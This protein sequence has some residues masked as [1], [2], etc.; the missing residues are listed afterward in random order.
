MSQN[1]EEDTACEF[2]IIFSGI[3]YSRI[4]YLFS[5]QY[6]LVR[7]T[8]A[9]F[10]TLIRPVFSGTRYWCICNH[11]FCPTFSRYKIL[12]HFFPLFCTIFSGTKYSHIFQQFFHTIFSAT[13]YFRIFSDFLVILYVVQNTHAFFTFFCGTKILH[14]I[15]E[16]AQESAQRMTDICSSGFTF[17][18]YCGT[19]ILW[20]SH[21]ICSYGLTTEHLSIGTRTFLDAPKKCFWLMFTFNGTILLQFEFQMPILHLILLLGLGRKFC[22]ENSCTVGLS[23]SNGFRVMK[24][25]RQLITWIGAFVDFLNLTLIHM[26]VQKA[27]HAG[28]FQ[29]H[30]GI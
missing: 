6:F 29:P 7:N 23:E 1:F 17:I 9:F 21:D 13:K 26:A 24:V 4:Y 2:C 27:P 3:E 19:K 15:I 8:Q 12:K 5:R 18:L 10:T 14:K 20:S 16:K 30:S 11:F 28:F 25:V 22:L